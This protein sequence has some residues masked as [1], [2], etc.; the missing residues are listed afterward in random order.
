MKKRLRVVRPTI[1]VPASTA[2]NRSGTKGF[3]PTTIGQNPH[4]EARLVADLV[5]LYGWTLCTDGNL[6]NSHPD[7]AQGEKHAA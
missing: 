2:G 6:Y 4:H 5:R 1:C 3:E 7:T